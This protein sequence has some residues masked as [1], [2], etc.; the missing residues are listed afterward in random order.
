MSEVAR[1]IYYYESLLSEWRKNLYAWIIR[2]P[3]LRSE[4]KNFI[5]LQIKTNILIFCD[6]L[7][8]IIIRNIL[9][10]II[11]ILHVVFFTLMHYLIWESENNI[12]K[13][14]WT[15]KKIPRKIIL[16]KSIFLNLKNLQKSFGGWYTQTFAFQNHT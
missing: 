10:I 16:K 6:N 9:N 7:F 11:I 2:N 14:P 5:C 1:Y 8:K 4:R 12:F 3:C 15:M 13:Q